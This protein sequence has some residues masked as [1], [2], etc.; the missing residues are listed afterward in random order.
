[1]PYSPRISVLKIKLKNQCL[2]RVASIHKYNNE[3]ES[4]GKVLYEYDDNNI[5]SN[6][7]DRERTMGCLLH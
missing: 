6:Q 2:Y 5:I 4:K 3:K 1:M 7:R